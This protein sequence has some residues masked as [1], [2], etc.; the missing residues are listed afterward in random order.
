[1]FIGKRS[2]FSNT[3]GN[4]NVFLGYQSGYSNTEGGSNIFLGHNNGR[5]N[6]TGSLNTFVGDRCGLLN[7][8]GSN[9]TYLGHKSGMYNSQG[10]NN[11][12]LGNRAGYNE[13]GSNKLYISNGDTPHPLIYG[14]FDNNI[15]ELNA[16]VTIGESTPPDPSAVL[17]IKSNDKGMLI[18]RMTE[19]EILT[20]VNPANGLQVFNL[21]DG[22]LYIYVLSFNKWKEVMYGSGEI[23]VPVD[24]SSYMIGA[25]GS[26]MNNN[27][28]GSYI[29]GSAIGP[30]HYVNLNAMVTTTGSWNI[31]TDTVNGYSFK[32]SGIF[33][34]TGANQVIL[35]GTGTPSAEQTDIFT[36]TASGII[37]TCTFSVIVEPQ[38]SCGAPINYDGQS[39]NTVQ[40]GSQCWMA[41]NLNIGT[42]IDG[43]IDQT[44]NG[45]IEKYCYNNSTSYCNTYGGLYQWGEM[46]NYYSHGIP[47]I[48]PVS[49]H[50][51][52][53]DEWKVLEMH[54]G[55]SASYAHNYDWRG[56]DQG[57]QLKE[58][59]TSHWDSPNSGATNSSGF[60]AL[61]G[62]VRFTNGSF[63]DL[64]HR[65]NFWTSTDWVGLFGAG[66]FFMFRIL[67]HQ[68]P[69]I[70]RTY[71]PISKQGFSVRC[72]RDY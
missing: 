4:V 17:D 24:P 68:S 67:S 27:V 60:T 28:N 62:G 51:P 13:T 48:C 52:S 61:P 34:V 30:L 44:D 38:V 71:I 72:V 19:A 1:V 69:Q 55:M 58:A 3:A 64:T 50:I 59:G 22:K 42:V 5:D 29:E 32:G 25:G 11:V 18:P 37:G 36:A 54:L 39:Y 6:T 12:F 45:T 57:G 70:S 26:C 35:Y 20:I 63:G 14:K 40:I 47:S 65:A 56:T 46:M 21:D 66:Y 7:T 49:W 23:N 43:A 53:D 41:E 16:Q 9:N 31:S 2:G 10:S 33:N 8:T 15:L